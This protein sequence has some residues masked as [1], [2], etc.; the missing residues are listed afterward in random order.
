MRI[1]IL[2]F[3]F[4][5]FAATAFPTRFVVGIDSSATPKNLADFA[6]RVGKIRKALGSLAPETARKVAS[7]NLHRVF[8]L[9]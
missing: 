5:L 2:H 8:R 3:L 6:K 4:G 9:P 7:D 1:G